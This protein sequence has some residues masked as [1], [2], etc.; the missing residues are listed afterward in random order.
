M[1]GADAIPGV[2]GGT[3]AL[4]L[5]IYERFIGALS[6]VVNAPRLVRSADG[7]SELI[8]AFRFLV[9]LGVGVLIAYYLATKLLVGP[10]DEPGVLR[11]ASTAPICFGFFFGLV[12]VSI[13]EPWRRIESVGAAHFAAAAVGFAAAAAFSHL[14]HSTG[15][16]D[17]WM[18]VLGGA[19]AISIMLLPG[20]SGSLFLLIIGQYNVVAGA[21]HDRDV[22]TLAVFAAGL[23]LGV[24]TF[25]PL[26]RWLLDRFHAVTMA[27]LTGLMAGSLFAL[28]PWKDNYEP[29]L[30]EMT[31]TGVGDHVPWVLLAAVVGGAVVWLL[32]VL[33][34]RLGTG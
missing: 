4:I 24:A 32:T 33:E 3:I 9:P 26:L 8:R 25:I 11:R 20:I 12:A 5:G 16:V 18:L 28:W 34:R 6:T 21:V 30:G 27:T 29:K 23:V 7:R 15:N 19:G 31:N 10:E 13:R 2:S 17:R 1:G 14:P 22:T